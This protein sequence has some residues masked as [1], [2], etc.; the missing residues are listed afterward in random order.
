MDGDGVVGGRGWGTSSTRHN[1]GRL[2]DTLPADR[3][4]VAG[5]LEYHPTSLHPTE[6]TV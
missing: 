4:V 5:G 6:P 1:H 2:P 3:N